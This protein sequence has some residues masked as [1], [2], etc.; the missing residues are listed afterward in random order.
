L[1]GRHEDC[2]RE[3]Q[4][5]CDDTQEVVDSIGSIRA[6]NHE[7]ANVGPGHRLG[8]LVCTLSVANYKIGLNS[9]I[10]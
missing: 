8:S 6:S 2:T 9:G 1:I 10:C 7:E 4:R 3:S 5:H